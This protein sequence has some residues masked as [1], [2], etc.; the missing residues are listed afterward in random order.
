[1]MMR[2][3]VLAI[4]RRTIATSVFQSFYSDNST[5]MF[6]PLRKTLLQRVKELNDVTY[7]TV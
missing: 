5:F 1:M 2:I 6:S 3:F 4:E 7:S